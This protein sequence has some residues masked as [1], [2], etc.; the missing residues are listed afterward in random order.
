MIINDYNTW[1]TIKKSYSRISNYKKNRKKYSNNIFIPPSRINYRGLN[2]YFHDFFSP[3]ISPVD[4]IFVFLFWN[5]K[6]QLRFGILPIRS[7]SNSKVFFHIS[8]VRVFFP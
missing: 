6:Y 8:E 2:F 3:Q 1:Y 4:N 7:T 5:L